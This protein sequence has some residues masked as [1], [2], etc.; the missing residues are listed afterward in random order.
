MGSLNF[1]GWEINNFTT[2]VKHSYFFP[3]TVKL[4]RGKNASTISADHPADAHADAPEPSG[5]APRET[6]VFFIGGHSQ[7]NYCAVKESCLDTHFRLRYHTEPLHYS[8]EFQQCSKA[9]SRDYHRGSDSKEDAGFGE[10][11]DIYRT[12]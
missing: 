3:S 11:D 1:V 10:I 5:P 4:S 6:L 2:I 8:A 9:R 7:L 12:Q